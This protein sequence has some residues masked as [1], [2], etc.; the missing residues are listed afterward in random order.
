MK[1]EDKEGGL[2]S[3]EETTDAGQ[4]PHHPLVRRVSKEEQ[5]ENPEMWGIGTFARFV[6]PPELQ[7]PIEE[8]N[9]MKELCAEVASSVLDC[10]IAPN[11]ITFGTQYSSEKGTQQIMSVRLPS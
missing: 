9:E 5:L 1:I 4:S 2:E 10:E 7:L 3:T 8:L 11:D 6:L